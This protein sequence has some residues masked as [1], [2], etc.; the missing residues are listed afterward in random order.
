MEWLLPYQI[1]NLIRTV[2]AVYSALSPTDTCASPRQ[3]LC[4]RHMAPV[5]KQQSLTGNMGAQMFPD[6][7]MVGFYDGAKAILIR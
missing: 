6:L 7:T 4:A 5:G 2:K 1:F 3:F